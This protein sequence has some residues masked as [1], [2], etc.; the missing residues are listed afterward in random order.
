[1]IGDKI[2]IGKMRLRITKRH[3]DNFTILTSLLG[4]EQ[5][6]LLDYLNWCL[7]EH[8]VADLSSDQTWINKIKNNPRA[9]S[10]FKERVEERTKAKWDNENILKIYDRVKATAEVH[11]RKQ[12]SYEELLRLLINSELKCSNPNCNKKPP[13]VKLHID[14]VFPSS[15][16][17]SSKF[18]NLQ[19]LCESCNLKKSNKLQ[20]SELWLKL[21]SLQLS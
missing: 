20:K 18:E 15:K 2:S 19:F 9:I 16:G 8:L 12:I 13:E 14:H 1:M 3:T 21:E 7:L 5:E 11:Y 10:I 6:S 17:G 4:V